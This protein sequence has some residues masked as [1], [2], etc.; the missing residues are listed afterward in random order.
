MSAIFRGNVGSEPEMRFTPNGKAVCGF[1]LALPQGKDANGEKLDALWVRVSC[2][3]D[4]AEIVNAQ[5]HKGQR[6]EVE[7]IIRL[8]AYESEKYGSVTAIEMTGF[9]VRMSEPGYRDLVPPR[10]GADVKEKE[11]VAKK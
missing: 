6:V 2:W 5:V 4:L 8:N 7:G 9:S 1:S 11:V 3:G 10:D